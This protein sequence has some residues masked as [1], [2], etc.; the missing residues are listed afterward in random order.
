[1]RKLKASQEEIKRREIQKAN[2]LKAFRE[3]FNEEINTYKRLEIEKDTLID[4]LQKGLLN[5]ETDNQAIRNLKK[6]IE[7]LESSNRKTVVDLEE[8][9]KIKEMR[10]VKFKKRIEKLQN[11]NLTK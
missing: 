7:S 2:E 10:L 11:D 9:I 1:M 8:T 5:A 4:D 3:Q 6:E